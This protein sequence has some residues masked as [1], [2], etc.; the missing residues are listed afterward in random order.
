MTRGR[1]DRDPAVVYAAARWF[2]QDFF[3]PPRR[4]GDTAQRIAI[5]DLAWKRRRTT[6]APAIAPE[7]TPHGP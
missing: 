1:A 2:V 5:V 6:E 7:S 4:D 3:A